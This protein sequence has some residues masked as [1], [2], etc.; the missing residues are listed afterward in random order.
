MLTVSEAARDRLLSKLVSRKADDDEAMRFTRRK[1][2]WKLRLERAC[3]GDAT[4][5]HHGRNVLLM[6]PDVSK[7]MKTM[8]LDV[9]QTVG[10]PRLTLRRVS[11]RGR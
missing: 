8:A 5:I 2:G 1:G 6:D 3:P 10:G 4:V 9:R 7:A 11:K